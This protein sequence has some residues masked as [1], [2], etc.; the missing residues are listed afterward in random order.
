MCAR[1]GALVYNF[2]GYLLGMD[3][4]KLI[5]WNLLNYY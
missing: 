5:Q 2:S 4:I 1:V 3:N